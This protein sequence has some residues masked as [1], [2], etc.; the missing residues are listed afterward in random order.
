MDSKVKQGKYSEGSIGLT[1][2]QIEEDGKSK[3]AGENLT[4]LRKA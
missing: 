4:A 1:Q 2:R 3:R